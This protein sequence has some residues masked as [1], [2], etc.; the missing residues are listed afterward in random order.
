[1]HCNL[2]AGTAIE[3]G[4]FSVDTIVRNHM[5]VHPAKGGIKEYK[6]CAKYFKETFI[7]GDIIMA[8]DYRLYKDDKTTPL[9][10]TMRKAVVKRWVGEPKR[11]YGKDLVLGPYPSVLEIVFEGEDSVRKILG[12]YLQGYVA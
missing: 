4:K 3:S 9:S 6:W 12:D 7:P 10:V 8:F 1:M 11:V 5:I 2:C